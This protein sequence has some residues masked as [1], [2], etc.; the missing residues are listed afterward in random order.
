MI[1]TGRS[2]TEVLVDP[3]AFLFRKFGD[4]FYQVREAALIGGEK[5]TYKK[6]SLGKAVYVEI[7]PSDSTTVAENMSPFTNW[8]TRLSAAQVR[9]RLA[10]YVKG[11]GALIDVKVKSRGV[12]KRVTELEIVTT[13]G[14]HSLKGGKIRSALR[15]PRAAFC[16]GQ[17]LRFERAC[18]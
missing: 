5:V 1:K 17:T 10:R 3:N 4:S 15:T 7:E 16:D 12:S 11:M 13:N 9:A 18:N 6:D 2:E 14:V 8:N